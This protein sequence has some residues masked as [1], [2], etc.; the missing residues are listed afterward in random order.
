MPHSWWIVGHSQVILEP[1][2]G[3]GLFR[4]LARVADFQRASGDQQRS[5]LT[6]LMGRFNAFAFA[7]DGMRAIDSRVE[8][9]VPG[10]YSAAQLVSTDPRLMLSMP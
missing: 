6:G 3:A 2:R 1:L 5:R 7:G 10:R 9:F 8:T 4:A